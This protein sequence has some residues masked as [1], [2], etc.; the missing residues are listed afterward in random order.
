[1]SSQASRG[2]KARKPV[3]IPVTGNEKEYQKRLSVWKK[4]LAKLLGGQLEPKTGRIVKSLIDPQQMTHP[5]SKYL[6]KTVGDPNKMTLF[7]EVTTGTSGYDL[8]MGL[9]TLSSRRVHTQ[10][11]GRY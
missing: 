4:D 3:R 6:T 8:E 7:P 5:R 10:H 2:I 9:Y 11:E 1:M